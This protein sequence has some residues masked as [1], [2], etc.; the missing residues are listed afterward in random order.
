MGN[1][2]TELCKGTHVEATV[3]DIG[4]FKIISK[5]DM[6]S[7]VCSIEAVAS[8][9][10]VAYVRTLKHRQDALAHMLKTSPSHILD[11]FTKLMDE[12]KHVNNTCITHMDR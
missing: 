1:I 5:S 9:A 11:K 3:E 10:D 8:V 4:L 6:S 12:H 2:S 7:G